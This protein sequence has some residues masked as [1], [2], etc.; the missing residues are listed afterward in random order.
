LVRRASWLV[1]NEATCVSDSEAMFVD[2]SA[3]T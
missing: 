3:A 1:L 2:V